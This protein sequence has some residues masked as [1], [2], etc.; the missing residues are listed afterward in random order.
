[1]KPTSC[2]ICVISVVV[3]I[4]ACLSGCSKDVTVLSKD[5]V[6]EELRDRLNLEQVT[7]TSDG[8]NAY[9][10]TAIDA[11]GTKV[12]LAIKVAQ[13]KENINGSTAKV[14]T[15]HSK[16]LDS[17][18]ETLKSGYLGATDLSN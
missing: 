3:A 9:R 17:N 6:S 13:E 12:V 14:T 5:E 4:T 16:L 15:I 11:D 1:M 10:G 7:L 2:H 18:G 8:E